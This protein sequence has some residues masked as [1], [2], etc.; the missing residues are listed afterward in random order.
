MLSVTRILLSLQSMLG[1]LETDS[2]D[3]SVEIIDNPLIKPVE[4]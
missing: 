4:L 2:Q 1:S 3:E